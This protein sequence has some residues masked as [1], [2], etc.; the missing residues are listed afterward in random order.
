MN[1]P[2]Y[3]RFTDTGGTQEMLM[4][5]G[6]PVFGIQAFDV[7][8][9]IDKGKTWFH[10]FDDKCVNGLPNYFSQINIE[11]DSLKRAKPP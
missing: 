2:K 5:H 3:I 1:K 9:S 6:W 8:V 7:D 4:G 11:L 10:L